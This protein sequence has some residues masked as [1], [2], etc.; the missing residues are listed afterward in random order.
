[1][2]D[3]EK[4]IS[5]LGALQP[6]EIEPTRRRAVA[7]VPGR[8]RRLRSPRTRRLRRPLMIGLATAALAVATIVV[9]SLGDGG[10]GRPSPAFAAAA[11]RFAESTPL[12]LLEAPGWRVQHA[13]EYVVGEGSAGS[14]EF[15]TG[16]AIPY[17]SI[18]ISG[19][20]RAERE[21]GMRP[22]SVRQRRVDLSW[23]HES[24]AGALG[25]QRTSPHPHGQHW[26]EMPVLG[27]MAHVD[28]RA[29]A[30]TNQ[31]GPG[32]RQMVAIWAEEGW[33][34]IMRAAVPDLA[35]FEE[36]LGRLTKVD[37]QTWL[38]AMPA[39]VV[40]ASSFKETVEE[41]TEGIPLPK[42]FAISRVPDEGLTIDRELAGFKVAGTI[43][44]LW[45]RQW[46]RARNDGD[47]AAELEAEEAMATSRHWPVLTEAEPTNGYAP[48]VW[49]LAASMKQGYWVWEG[50]KQQLL[51]HGESLGCARFGLP[52]KAK[53]IQ[54]QKEHGV[55][56]PPE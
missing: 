35:A 28:T 8:A 54:R 21:S 51:Y 27:T 7:V 1:M 20:P 24:S 10:P 39:A 34:L 48:L 6:P 22:P 23:R 11:V 19:P 25:I 38:E 33:T 55:L 13:G 36:R 17:E 16:K 53:N 14:M 45:L 12:L 47:T 46:D 37:T 44:C 32:N 31:G 40:K 18:T 9:L 42:T 3:D 56:P 50:H 26:V 29:E 5:R 4:L 41:M 30:Y 49:Q 43:S 15:V 52:L 2:M